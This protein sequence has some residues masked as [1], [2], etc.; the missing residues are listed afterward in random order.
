MQH[1]SAWSSSCGVSG[2]ILLLA[3][4]CRQLKKNLLQFAVTLS[5]RFRSENFWMKS[6]SALIATFTFLISKLSVGGLKSITG[7]SVDAIV[8]HSG[9]FHHNVEFANIV[10]SAPRDMRSAGLCWVETCCHV[11][12]EVFSCMKATLLPT[13]VFHRWDGPWIHVKTIVESVHKYDA[14]IM[15]WR[16]FVTRLYNFAKS[17]AAHN[18]NLGIVN[19]F[20]WSNPW[21]R[22]QQMTE[23]L[24]RL[25]YR[26]DVHA[27]SISLFT[28]ITKSMKMDCCGI[29]ANDLSW[30]TNLCQLW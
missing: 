26:S 3:A 29:G 22:T 9:P 10:G 8:I 30:N 13:K 24:V 21:W 11:E 12:E 27:S 6:F 1:I 19:F 7:Q 18:S 16:A 5:S 15:L 14:S 17:T 20:Q 2:A 4:C 23:R 25:I 28:R